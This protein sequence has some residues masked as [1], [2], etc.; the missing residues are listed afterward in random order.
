MP[1][2]RRIDRR[3][4]GIVVDGQ[5]KLRGLREVQRNVYTYSSLRLR[6]GCDAMASTKP[7]RQRGRHG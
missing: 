7:R 6:V 2:P 3:S 4:R 1:E 5:V